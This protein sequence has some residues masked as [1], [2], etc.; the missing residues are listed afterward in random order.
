MTIEELI[1]GASGARRIVF[2]M[3]KILFLLVSICFSQLFASQAI[4]DFTEQKL[5]DFTTLKIQLKSVD[6]KEALAQIEDL[7]KST[8]AELP[9]HA[10]DFEQEKKLLEST[11]FM[12]SYEHL[13]TTENRAELRKIMKNHMNENI[14]CIN[15][16]KENNISPWLYVVTGDVTAYYMTRSI[17][18][19]LMYG[20][21]IKSWYE[22]GAEGINGISGAS[23]SLGNW[24]FYAPPPF[25]GKKKAL[26]SYE[27]AVQ[28]AKTPGE[29]YLAYEFLSQLYFE[30]KNSKK[31]AEYLQKAYDL[32]LGAKELNKVKKCNESGYSL[33][34]YNRNRAGIDEKIP[35]DEME[36]DDK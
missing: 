32:N 13:I 12:E 10:I 1:I 7:R 30:M 3:K 22:K 9:S 24:L 28:Q 2:K 25:G 26:E 36:E 17:P 21:K 4:S 15:A 35:E 14:D 11:Y 6:D 8:L 18:A 23:M 5:L 29:L 34:Q 33:Y 31:S 20:L 16:R 19:T 27:K